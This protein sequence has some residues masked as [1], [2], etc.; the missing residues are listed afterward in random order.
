[1]VSGSFHFLHCLIK[2]SKLGHAEQIYSWGWVGLF[3]VKPP[4]HPPTWILSVIR[5]EKWGAIL[6]FLLQVETDSCGP[7]LLM[8]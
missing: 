5:I 3:F 1:M 2:R 7:V 8:C 4:A 6:F